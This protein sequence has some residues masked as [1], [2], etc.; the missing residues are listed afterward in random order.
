VPNWSPDDLK[1]W[2]LNND[3]PEAA[4]NA[5]ADQQ[6][7]GSDIDTLTAVELREDMGIDDGQ[8]ISLILDGIAFL[9]HPTPPDKVFTPPKPATPPLVAAGSVP[10]GLGPAPVAPVSLSRQGSLDSSSKST[11]KD[12]KDKKSKRLSF[13]G[14]K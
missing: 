11:G 10:A 2:F 7:I 5:F 12:A 13:L 9:L 4:A 3:C 1:I 14:R 6:I 8:I